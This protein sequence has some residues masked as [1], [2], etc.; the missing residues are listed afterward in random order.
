MG[1]EREER[2]AMAEESEREAIAAEFDR[3]ADE[4]AKILHQ[5]RALSEQ[6]GDGPTAFIIGHILTEEE[7]HHFLLINLAKWLRYPLAGGPSAGPKGEL[8]QDLLLR[9]RKLQEHERETIEACRSLKSRLPGEEGDLL[10]TLLDA[11]ALDSEK[12]DRLLS[13]VAKMMGA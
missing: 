8:R 3:H 12:H 6:L 2:K 11:M 4:E 9:T 1:K 13:A 5:Y 10:R 7:L